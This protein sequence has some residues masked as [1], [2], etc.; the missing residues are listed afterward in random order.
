MSDSDELM[1]RY[2]ELLSTRSLSEIAAPK[3]G[4]PRAAKIALAE[5]QVARFHGAAGATVARE[6]FERVV[7]RKERPTL[8]EERQV[9]LPGGAPLPLFV[10]VAEAGLAKSRS[11]ARRLVQQG[12]VQLGGEKATDPMVPLGPGTYDLQVGKLSFAR[13]VLSPA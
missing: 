3:A 1:W 4:H 6:H 5:E 9:A 8:V 2:C 11:D 12:G 7:V 10:V 13:V